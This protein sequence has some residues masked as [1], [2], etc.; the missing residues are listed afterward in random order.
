MYLHSQKSVCI[1]A[2]IWKAA[3]K[4]TLCGVSQP[5]ALGFSQL[6]VNKDSVLLAEVSKEGK[7][8]PQLTRSCM[9]HGPHASGSVCRMG[10]ED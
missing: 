6:L 1:S 7:R 2:N 4:R 10:G 9:T 3:G 8:W 5:A